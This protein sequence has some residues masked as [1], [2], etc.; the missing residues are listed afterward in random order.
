[1]L[2]DGAHNEEGVESLIKAI[3]TLKPGRP[4]RVVVA[5]LRDKKLDRMIADLC[6]IATKT[7][8]ISK[9]K[10][11]RAAE[12]EEQVEAAQAAGTPFE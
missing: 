6:T 9:N 1:V 12:V 4:C 2:I 10:S 5:I 11:T 3:K 8:Y 7:L